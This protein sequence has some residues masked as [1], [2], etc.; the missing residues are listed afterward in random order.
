M[1][2]CRPP[3]CPPRARIWSGQL[4]KNAPDANAQTKSAA[5]AFAWGRVEE[6]V[7]ERLVAQHA[8]KRRSREAAEGL[9]SFAEKRPARWSA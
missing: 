2:W 7:V 8:A 4:L 3:S 6:A 9:A 1:R 5:L